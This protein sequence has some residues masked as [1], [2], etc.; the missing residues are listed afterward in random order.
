MN[1]V[2]EL[3]YWAFG[4]NTANKWRQRLGLDINPVW[5][6]I[7]DKMAP[8]PVKNNVYISEE[9]C[10]DTFT[11]F[12]YDHPSMLAALG[13]LPGQKVDRAI[14]LNT[15]NKVM[16]DWRMDSVWGWDFPMIAM[17]AARLGKP[18]I[19]IE[20]LLYDSPKNIYLP[21]GHNRQVTQGNNPLA[22]ETLPLYLPGNGG[23]L[24]AA[25]MMAAGWTGY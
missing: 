5:K 3:E 2:Y 1:P 7:A 23:L 6:E 16:T 15:L 13:V 22:V 20:A 25:A 18:E 24:A 10:P 21:N 19:A 4:L 11:K 12:N 8:L 9:N 14:M 17:T